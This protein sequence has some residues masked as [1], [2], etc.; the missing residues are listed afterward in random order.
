MLQEIDKCLDAVQGVTVRNEWFADLL[1]MLPKELRS[2]YYAGIPRFLLP[3][4]PPDG[5]E[6]LIKPV[7]AWRV[8]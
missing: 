7:S 6:K 2:H 5:S 3:N 8:Q 1:D 4:A